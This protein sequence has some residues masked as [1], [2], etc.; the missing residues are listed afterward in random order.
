MLQIV[1]IIAG[2]LL[3]IAVVRNIAQGK[4]QLRYS[5]VWLLLSVCAFVFAIWPQPLTA[6][7]SLLGFELTSNMILLGGITGLALI[8]FAQGIAITKLEKQAKELTQAVA[9]IR[10]EID[11][12][13]RDE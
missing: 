1:M 10:K 5:L 7:A 13:N 6:L 3:V 2:C 4:L 12:S 11:Q 9:L 8:V